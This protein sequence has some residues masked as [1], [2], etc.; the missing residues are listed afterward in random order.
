MTLRPRIQNKFNNKKYLTFFSTISVS[1]LNI[2]FN[3]LNQL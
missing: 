1:I 2:F 3:Q